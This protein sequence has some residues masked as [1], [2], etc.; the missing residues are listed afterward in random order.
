MQHLDEGE[1]TLVKSGL[2]KMQIRDPDPRQF[3]YLAQRLEEIMT[4]CS[5][6]TKLSADMFLEVSGG[7]FLIGTERNRIIKPSAE[8]PGSQKDLHFFTPGLNGLSLL[9]FGLH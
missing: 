8:N 7:T 6:K 5:R 2:Q 9:R 1:N 4:I 3:C